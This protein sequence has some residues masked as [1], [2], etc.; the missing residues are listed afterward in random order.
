ML[1]AEN[2]DTHR[3]HDAGDSR[4]NVSNNE[5]CDDHQSFSTAGL[6]EIIGHD[7]WPGHAKKKS[8]VVNPRDVSFA[9]VGP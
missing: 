3:Q 1:P 7:D 5:T 2:S 4:A 8:H 9:T 6:E